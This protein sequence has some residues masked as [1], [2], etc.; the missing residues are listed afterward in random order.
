MGT[1]FGSRTILTICG[2]LVVL[3]GALADHEPLDWSILVG[4][5][6]I[7]GGIA[8]ANLRRPKTVGEIETAPAA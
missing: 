8:F 7:I 6:L 2:A 4:A 5:G 3:L 1:S